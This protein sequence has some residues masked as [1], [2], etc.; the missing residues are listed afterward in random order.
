MKKIA[1]VL[2]LS[3]PSLFC[4]LQNANAE[5][6]Q[7]DKEFLVKQCQ[8]AQD[9]VDII[10]KLKPEIQN[11]IASFVAAKDCQSLTVFKN[12]RDYYRKVKQ[13]KPTDV[14]PMP[15]KWDSNYLTEEE[16]KNFTAVEDSMQW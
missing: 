15:P 2:L 11:K 4:A 7:A 5:L 12:S 14:F 9:D 13:L 6:S 3:L 16:Q 10:S 1:L 8:I